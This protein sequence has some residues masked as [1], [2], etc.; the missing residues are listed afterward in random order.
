M[1]VLDHVRAMSPER[2]LALY[3]SLERD[4]FGPLDGE[5]ARALHFRPHAIRKLP[6]PQRAKRARILIES[7]RNSDLAYEIVGGYLLKTR[8]DLVTAFLDAT[9]V[10][11]EEG[12]IEDVDGAK[13]EKAKIAA[14]IQDLDSRF[15]PEDVTLYLVMCVDQWPDVPEFGKIL[16]TRS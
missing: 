5:V 8:R 6:M 13:P 12:M 9:G 3:Q 14:A 7:S 15:P 16:A 2:F 4:G 1:T 10:K 11:H